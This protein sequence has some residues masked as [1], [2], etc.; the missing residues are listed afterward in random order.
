MFL[1]RT[2]FFCF[3]KQSALNSLYATPQAFM[4]NS[5]CSAVYI[6]S[7]INRP[8]ILFLRFIFFIMFILMIHTQLLMLLL[9]LLFFSSLRRPLMLRVYFFA[10]HLVTLLRFFLIC[11]WIFVFL[12][13]IMFEVT[14]LFVCFGSHCDHTWQPFC[15][16]LSAVS[17]SQFHENKNGWEFVFFLFFIVSKAKTYANVSIH[18]TKFNR[19]NFF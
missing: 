5:L 13:W 18:N 9:L 19:K 2:V 11:V 15:F 7:R 8:L 16:S 1:L 17:F 3:V 12:F 14:F 6:S 10:I 4:E